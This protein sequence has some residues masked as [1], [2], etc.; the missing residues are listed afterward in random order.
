MASTVPVA[1]PRFPRSAAGLHA[2]LVRG[3]APDSPLD[4]PYDGTF[5]RTTINPMLDFL[6]AGGARFYMGWLGK[7]FW[8]ATQRGDNHL[9]RSILI[10][11]RLLWPSY[12]GITNHADGTAHA[13]AFR[14]W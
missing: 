2:E 9:R 4:G 7:R 8:P 14:T 10:P 3:R 6:L 12:R 11:A 1:E 5:L 13:L